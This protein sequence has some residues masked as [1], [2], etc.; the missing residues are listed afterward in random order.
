MSSL[1][2]QLLRR[3]EVLERIKCSKSKLYEDILESKFPA[4]IKQ[5]RNSYWVAEEVANWIDSRI[6]ERDAELERKILERKS[7]LA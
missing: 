1:L 6:A 4:P 5:G 7:G 3:A 2:R